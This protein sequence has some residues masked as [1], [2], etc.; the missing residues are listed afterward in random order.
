MSKI[1]EIIIAYGSQTGNAEYIAKQIH[2]EAGDR[3][4]KARVFTLNDCLKKVNWNNKFLLIVVTSST[5]DGDPPDNALQFFKKKNISKLTVQQYG[6]LGLGD[7]NYEN[8]NNT[9]KRLDKILKE[10]GSEPIIEKGLADDA[11]GLE[12][13]VE[14]WLKKLW[15]IIPNYVLKDLEKEEEYKSKN[16]AILEGI[17][18]IQIDVKEIDQ[19]KE[20]TNLAKLPT[21]TLEIQEMTE[22]GKKVE[23]IFDICGNSNVCESYTLREPFRGKI[24]GGRIMTGKDAVK[25]VLE[26]EIDIKGLE[27]DYQCGDVIG[28]V[29]PNPDDLVFGLIERLKLDPLML[30]DLK[31]SKDYG[32]KTR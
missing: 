29:C 23:S 8:F 12:E 13:V 2:T 28:I 22:K 17:K 26:V 11:T 16:S 18:N 9:A 4:Y 31:H 19:V 5:G 10:L 7:S 15:E 3:G 14:E 24:V 30:F 32:L 21:T 6:I 20:L 1:E 27:W 25:K